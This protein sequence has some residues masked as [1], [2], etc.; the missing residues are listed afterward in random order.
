MTKITRRLARARNCEDAI[1]AFRKIELFGSSKGIT[2]MN[3]LMDALVKQGS[4]EHAER[5]YF[6][7]KN[8][9]PPNSQTFSVLVHGWCKTRQIDKAQETIERDDKLRICP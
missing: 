7:F 1:E 3:R 4:V 9:I 6:E 8:H 2:S 5:V